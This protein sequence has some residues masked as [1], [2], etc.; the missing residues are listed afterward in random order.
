MP[1]S[2]SKRR[3]RTREE[4]GLDDQD[5][6]GMP[7]HNK[8]ADSILLAFVVAIAVVIILGRFVL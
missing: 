7:E 3:R 5:R 4:Q 1:N 8:G 6:E 2:E